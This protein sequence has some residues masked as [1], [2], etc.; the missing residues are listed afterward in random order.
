MDVINLLLIAAVV[1]II[2]GQVV[3]LPVSSGLGAISVSD[4]AVAFCDLFFL[5]Y[6]LSVKKSFKIFP[7]TFVPAIF[8][9][10]SAL[11]SNILAL[12]NFLPFQVAVSSL[13]LL[14]FVIYFF[15]SIVI[16]NAVK[17]SEV[18]SFLNVLGAAGFIF[19]IIGFAQ[20]IVF[21]DF[22]A[23][24]VFGWDPHQE[25]IAS[26]FLDPNFSGIIFAGVFAFAICRFLYQTTKKNLQ[27]FIYL[28]LSIISFMAVIFTFSRSSYL[29][30]LTVI[31]VVGILKSLRLLIASLMI[32][33]ILF[34]AIGGVR[35]RII[36]AFEIDETAQSRILSWQRALVVFGDN[37]IFGVGFN[38]YRFAQSKY[39]FFSFDEPLGGHSGGGTDSSILLTAV[40]CG[41]IGLIFY[42]WFLFSIFSTFLKKAKSS[43]LH[44]ASLS[45]FLGLIVHSQFVNSLFFPQI[46][47]YLFFILGLVQA[48]DASS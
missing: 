26:T 15:L 9:I 24:T 44:L 31:A 25:R 14:R 36:G 43:F 37:P 45:F 10:L 12:N 38:T 41:I 34:L 47:L 19:I 5:I 35:Q 32:F 13:F 20:V 8:F 22:S 11:V 27:G 3:R 16:Y 7:K 23:L 39:N 21:P 33:I 28:S 29:A 17:K 48:Y 30:L 6:F 18:E 42:L 2:P 4:I 40:T 46:M 1:S